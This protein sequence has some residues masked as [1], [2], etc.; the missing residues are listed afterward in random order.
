MQYYVQVRKC[1]HCAYRSD[2]GIQPHIRR[3]HPEKGGSSLADT[4][5]EHEQRSEDVQTPDERQSHSNNNT[6][7]EFDSSNSAQFGQNRDQLAAVGSWLDA[8]QQQ[9]SSDRN[10]NDDDRDN[11]EDRDNAD[12]A[13]FSQ[14]LQAE[15]HLPA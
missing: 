9:E 5:S 1:P 14:V 2:T 8:N 12:D 3:C 11:N 15:K 13:L 7:M 10:N 4:S 6:S